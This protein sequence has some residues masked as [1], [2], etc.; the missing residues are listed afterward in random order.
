MKRYR[1][2]ITIITLISIVLVGFISW[3]NFQNSISLLPS[4]SSDR[5]VID[6]IRVSYGAYFFLVCAFF[7]WFIWKVKKPAKQIVEEKKTGMD[8]REILFFSILILIIVLLHVVTLSKFVPW[9]E[10][11]L[12]SKP[13][14]EKSFSIGIADYQFKFPA[15]PMIIPKSRFVE[16]ILTSN[17]VTYGF[18]VF[19]KDGSL[20]FQLQVIPGYKNRYVWNFT[21]PGYY[22]VRSTEYSGPNHSD[23]FVKDVIK[24]LNEGEKYE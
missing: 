12:W 18:G 17:D 24:V 13:E 21:E 11:R 5:I 2:I 14:I 15:E 4:V 6:A 22:D 1:I 3:Y 23:M 9:Q 20:V 16:F 7:V 10:W 19:R 8:W